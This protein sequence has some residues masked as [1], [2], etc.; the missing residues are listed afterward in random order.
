MLTP[1]VVLGVVATSA[2]L[3]RQ[4]W[5]PRADAL[6]LV[7]VFLPVYYATIAPYPVRFDR[8]LIPALPYL[9][10]LGGFGVA[11]A[12]SRRTDR[13]QSCPGREAAAGWDAAESAAS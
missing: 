9:A 11:A 8:Q 5:S 4:R 2:I 1:V 7:L 10:I 3:I 12:T 6:A 13:I